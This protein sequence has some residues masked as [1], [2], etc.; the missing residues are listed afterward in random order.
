MIGLVGIKADAGDDAGDAVGFA[1]DLLAEAEVRLL[2]RLSAEEVAVAEVLELVHRVVEHDRLACVAVDLALTRVVDRDASADQVEL[3]GDHA[4]FAGDLVL[5]VGSE[6]KSV[7]SFE[8]WCIHD[9]SIIP[10]I[11]GV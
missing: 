10:G 4:L 2:N 5:D 8:G 6:V 9:V 1:P 3:G 11:V 7:V